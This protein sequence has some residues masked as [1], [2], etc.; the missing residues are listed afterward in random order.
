MGVQLIKAQYENMKIPKDATVIAFLVTGMDCCVEKVVGDYAQFL[1]KDKIAIIVGHE[2]RPSEVMRMAPSLIVFFRV[3]SHA[4][5]PR[6]M[7]E[8]INFQEHLRRLNL[9]TVYYADDMLFHMNNKA[10]LEVARRCDE[11]IVTCDPLKMFLYSIGIPNPVTTVPSHMDVNIFDT[12][13]K[14]LHSIPG[15]VNVLLASSGRVGTMGLY[16]LVSHMNDT[17]EKYKDVN[18]I[19][20]SARVAQMRSVINKFRGIKKSYYEWMQPQEFYSLCKSVDIM[21]APC[22]PGDTDY[23]MPR[24]LQL[25]YLDS[26]SPV[27]YLIAGAAGIPIISSKPLQYREAIQHGVTGLLADTNEEFITYFDILLDDPEL[28]TRIGMAARKDVEENWN[29]KDRYKLFKAALFGEQRPVE[30]IRDVSKPVKKI[31]WLLCGDEQVPSARIE[32]INISDW[33]STNTDIKSEIIQKP[34]KFQHYVM[35]RPGATEKMVRNGFDAIVF[36]KVFAGDAAPMARQLR[37]HG[38]K[39]YYSLSDLLLP[40]CLPLA[41]QCNGIIVGSNELRNR[42]PPSIQGK[43]VVIPDAYETPKD[44]YKKDYKQQGYRVEV[45]WFGSEANFEGAKF[46][47]PLIESLEWNYTMIS[48]HSQAD[49]KWALDTIWNDLMSADIVVI[50]SGLSDFELCKDENKVVQCMVLG[51]PVIA[52]PIPAYSKVIQHGVTGY[53]IDNQTMWGSYLVQLKD[54]DRRQ[55]MGQAGR[56][57]VVEQYNIDAIVKRWLEVIN[58][59]FNI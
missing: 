29:V 30:V 53:L 49:K 48:S 50:P 42:F 9:R 28:R 57:L 36:Q 16:H 26:K 15:M 10:P 59:N 24:E 51:L 46:L 47:R 11:I 33:I 20:V 1:E 39:V 35:M 41:E 7:Q 32:G 40:V 13:P 25:L 5:S 2:G 54:S 37:S 12:Y 38:V 58:E 27:K 22:E 45:V 6:S 44:L 4:E 18:L 52:S 43:V 17:P 8:L 31:G 21:L 34:P 14:S 3:G 56:E 23:F 55:A 19:I